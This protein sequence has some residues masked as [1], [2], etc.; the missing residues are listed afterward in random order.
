MT[1][2]KQTVE[3][4]DVQNLTAVMQYSILWRSQL[5][6]LLDGP[7]ESAYVSCRTLPVEG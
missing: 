5:G 2:R 7:S 6:V 3:W 1:E 4:W